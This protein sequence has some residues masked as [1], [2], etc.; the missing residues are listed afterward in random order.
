MILVTK[1][2]DFENGLS[3]WN[4]NWIRI[5]NVDIALYLY[6]LFIYKYFNI[7]IWLH[8]LFSFKIIRITQTGEYADCSSLRN[9]CWS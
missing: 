7:H 8:I 2:F 3:F 4:I 5:L 1:K 9:A 6:V